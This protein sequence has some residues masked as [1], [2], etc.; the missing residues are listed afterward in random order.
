M[1]LKSKFVLSVGLLGVQCFMLPGS[2]R[3]D[4][5]IYNG[6]APDGNTLYFAD[7]SY[8]W[9]TDGV[10]FV[11]TSGGSTVADAEWWGACGGACPTGNFTL[12]FYTNNSGQPG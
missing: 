10:G 2:L 12:G 1:N 4:S 7:Q 11:L 6:G 3:A 5:T 9:T 8:P